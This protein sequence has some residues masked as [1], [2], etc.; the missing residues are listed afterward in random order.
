LHEQ[1][2]DSGIYEMSCRQAAYLRLAQLVP[3]ERSELLLDDDAR[4]LGAARHN[5]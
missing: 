2:L 5:W 3:E 4:A 1:P